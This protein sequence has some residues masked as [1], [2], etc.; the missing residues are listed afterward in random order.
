VARLRSTSAVWAVAVSTTVLALVEHT[1]APWRPFYVVYAAMCIAIPL[2]AGTARLQWPRLPVW[3]WI[4][5]V[6]LPFALQGLAG[7]WLGSV[8]PAIVSVIGA[9]PDATSILVVLPSAIARH[10]DAWSI[11]PEELVLRYVVF[12]TIWAGFGEELLYRGYVHEVLRERSGFGWAA[13]V[14]SVWF[15]IRHAVQLVG[16]PE[17]PWLAATSWVLFG[18]GLG[19]VW[20]W[21][22]ERTRSLWPPIIVHTLFNAIPLAQMLLG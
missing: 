14:S 9:D 5:V 12:I 16:G 18:C 13:L 8:W 3:A 17:Y 10:V 6:A 2:F 22:Y 21:L 15:G 4:G 11:P 20:A 7:V 19:L 1:W